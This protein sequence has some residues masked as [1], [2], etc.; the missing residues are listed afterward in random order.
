MGLSKE[1]YNY[2]NATYKYLAPQLGAL[3]TLLTKSHDPPSRVQDFGWD[4][5]L[6]H[7]YQICQGCPQGFESHC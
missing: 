4:L 3:A 7:Q 5:G 2:G 1:G 6:Y